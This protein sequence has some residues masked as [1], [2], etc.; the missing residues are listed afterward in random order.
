MTPVHW[1]AR[2]NTGLFIKLT[3]KGAV[4]S[5][6]FFSFLSTPVH[7]DTA[8]HPL[9][10]LQL[11]QLVF[12]AGGQQLH[13]PVQVVPGSLAVFLLLACFCC[14]LLLHLTLLQGLQTIR[15][16]APTFVS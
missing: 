12:P 15:P 3:L 10:L 5:F 14:L 11:L 6:P 16:V 8:R 1:A 2:Y 13:R 4:F 7:G 9:P